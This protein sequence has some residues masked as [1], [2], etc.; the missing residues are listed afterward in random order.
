MNARVRLNRAINQ[1][2]LTGA[3]APAIVS[4]CVIN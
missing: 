3:W 1:I 2:A 4:L